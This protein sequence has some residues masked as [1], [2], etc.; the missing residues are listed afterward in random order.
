VLVAVLLVALGPPAGVQA[1]PSPFF[2]VRPFESAVYL[3][4]QE[5]A[6]N[7]EVLI[8]I[9]DPNTA[10]AVDFSMTART[11]GSGFF[12]L[13]DVP[14]GVEAGNVVTLSQGATVKTHVVVDLAVTRMGIVS[15]TVSGVG[16]PN[17]ETFVGASEN[18]QEGSQRT[19]MSD[20]AGA[21]TADFSVPG[22]GGEPAFDVGPEAKIYTNQH[23]DDW[24]M[25]GITYNYQPPQ[26]W[27]R[28]PATGH[29]Y[30]YV[31]DGM[32]WADAD[33][34]AVSLG[35][36][37]VT[38][39]DAAEDAWLVATFGTEY[40]VGFNDT[41]TEGEWAWVSGE[42]VTFTNWQAGEPND[43]PSGEDAAV[44]W[45][46]PATGWNDFRVDLSLPFVVEVSPEPVAA[47]GF[48]ASVPLPTK[49]SQDPEVIGTN[50]VLALIFTAIFGF[51]STLF[52]NTL[53]CK[54]AEI[55][56]AA[57]R[58]RAVIPRLAWLQKLKSGSPRLSRRWVERIAIVAVTGL[59]YAFLDPNFGFSANGLLIFVSLAVSL[60]IVTYSYEGVQALASSRGYRVPARLRLFPAAIAIA[61]ICVIIS[62]VSGFTPGY[63]YGFVGGLAFLGA[64]QPDD[65]KKGRLVL[66]AAA[67]L[68][69]VSLA[70]WFLAW[71]LTNAIG[72]GSSWLEVIQGI[73]VATF[74]AGL[75]GLVFG[76]VP[77]SFMDG[78]T[79][80]RW[81]KW[82]WGGVFGVA[83]FLF[84]HV[85]LNKHGKYGAALEQTSAKVVIGLL[86]FWVVAAVATYWYFR[87]PRGKAAA[88][89]QTP[90]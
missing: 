8:E 22:P 67:C 44:L 57:G 49:I 18:N 65:R 19:V 53:K 48:V 34:Y 58:L 85:L 30:W 82:V 33:A 16:A 2:E 62:R 13:F 63:L 15:D 68:L 7:S 6:P 46:I 11:D 90:T 75:E 79:L 1:A 40:W 25:T 29:D 80:F 72:A 77:L 12:E 69:V 47:P 24:D 31:E 28:N 20:D 55:V 35:G 26:G 39:N 43:A 52:N 76:L 59:I 17:T 21:W 78:A 10:E 36:H 74:V 5:W 50:F 70:A 83:V 4:G 60:A 86:A 89:A 32:S 87:K 71:P 41:A 88:E 61:I 23:D 9:D 3:W 66:L 81:N 73:C 37:L 56:A 42:P 51:T 45:S 27:Q 38:I 14:F 64:A 84:W 54:N